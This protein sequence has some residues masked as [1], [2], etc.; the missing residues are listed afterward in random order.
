MED[1]AESAF[2]TEVNSA[3]QASEAGDET[4]KQLDMMSG[5]GPQPAYEGLAR[6]LRRR[7]AHWHLRDDQAAWLAEQEEAL[8]P[9]RLE[10]EVGDYRMHDAFV[11]NANERV[12]TPEQFAAIY[13]ADL[14]L[15]AAG[16]V[17]AQE[18]IAQLIRQ[19]VAEHVATNDVAFSGE[20]LRV[21]I[22]LEVQVG[23]L[24]LRDR[25]EWDI[26]EPL[27]SRPEEFARCLCRELG[28][29]GEY[30]PL[31]AH[32]IREEVARLRK[33][34]ADA[35]DAQWLRQPA[36]DSIFRPM[37]MA[38]SWGPSI[39][40]MSA[41][42]MDK[43]WVHKERSYRRMRRSERGQT[44]SF[45]FLPPDA[46]PQDPAGA[47]AAGAAVPGIN[48]AFYTQG[49]AGPGDA[50]SSGAS[51]PQL[52][53]RAHPGTRGQATPS[54]P[55]TPRSYSKVDVD[56]WECEHCGCDSSV[57]PIQRQGPNGPKTLCNACGIAWIVR[58]RQELP[59][60]RKN[61]FRK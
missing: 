57:T 50:P 31:V 1:E 56:T 41:E 34:L 61:K 54:R 11:W 15:P 46:I 10:L 35:G 51:S 48:P 32:R 14:A 2:E 36:V 20:E 53:R 45:N 26:A 43:M 3:R 52:S 58:D 47:A 42:D 17:G 60:S 29:G 33:D 7:T 8:V 4:G 22:D 6:R 39:E 24:V 5:I 49:L 16:R 9:I 44:R 12:V 27:G 23:P 28:L 37:N 40:I 18:Y 21:N 25:I 19:Q 59:G 55:L 38:E 30:P 13:C